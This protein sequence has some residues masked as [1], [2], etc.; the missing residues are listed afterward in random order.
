[1]Y[2]TKYIKSLSMGMGHWLDWPLDL[3]LANYVHG[4]STA[5]LPFVYWSIQLLHKEI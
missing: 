1:M 5:P 3:W 4:G 2:F